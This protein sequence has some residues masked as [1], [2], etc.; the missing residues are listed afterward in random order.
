MV[1][2]HLAHSSLDQ[3][4]FDVNVFL[5]QRRSVPDLA[6]FANNPWKED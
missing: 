6:V 5:P 2:V 1:A 4:V 3:Q